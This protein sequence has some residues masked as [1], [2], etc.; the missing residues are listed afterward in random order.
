MSDFNTLPSSDQAFYN[1]AL[2]CSLRRSK[3]QCRHQFD[4]DMCNQC[5][6]YIRKFTRADDAAIQMLFLHTDTR[7]YQYKKEKRMRALKYTVILGL[8]AIVLW[9][10]YYKD[11]PGRKPLF[12]EAPRTTLNNSSNVYDQINR[13][14]HQVKYDMD[15]NKDYDKNGKINCID[16]SVSFYK[17]FPDKTKVRLVSNRNAS[18]DFNHL[19]VAVLIDEVWRAIEPQ[20]YWK[21]HKDYFMRD[22]WGA[23]YDSS[24]NE[25]ETALYS[26]YAR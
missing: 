14:L 12:F 1:I 2:E 18:K 6:V 19:F 16:A 8:I 11:L 10:G 25:D 7:A 24:L 17:H 9:K 21:N 3:G 20:A 5:G 15:R 4:S 26:R 13:T 23:K 22:Y